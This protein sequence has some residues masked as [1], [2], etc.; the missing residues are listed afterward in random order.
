MSGVTVDLGPATGTPSL[1]EWPDRCSCCGK[2]SPGA[3]GV[4]THTALSSAST[5]SGSVLVEP[6]R[7][8][9]QVPTC[10]DCLGHQRLAAATSPVSPPVL[11]GLLVLLWLGIGWPLFSLGL[12]ED[13]VAIAAYATVLAAAGAAGYVFSLWLERSGERRA[14]KAMSPACTAPDQAVRAVSPQRRLLLSFSSPSYGRDFA[15]WNGLK[16]E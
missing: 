2:P 7:M 8:R 15:S 10:P 4:H 11:A 13:I 6:V 16:A 5:G 14:R 3:H 1:L 12:S 9:W